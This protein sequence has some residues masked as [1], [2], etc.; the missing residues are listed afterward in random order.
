MHYREANA[1]LDSNPASK[2]TAFAAGIVNN[3]N[4]GNI[5]NVNSGNSNVTNISNTNI[6]NNNNVVNNIV[7]NVQNPTTPGKVSVKYAPVNLAASLF[8]ARGR[9]IW[10]LSCF[11]RKN[12]EQVFHYR[13]TGPSNPCSDR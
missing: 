12:S 10:N 9:I 5:N 11:W 8:S 13:S 1:N 4:S 7:N 2:D 3:V 6:Q